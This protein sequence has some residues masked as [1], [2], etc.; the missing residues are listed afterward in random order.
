MSVSRNSSNILHYKEFCTVLLKKNIWN[1]ENVESLNPISSYLLPQYQVLAPP[2]Q[3]SSFYTVF[4]HT[5]YLL[6]CNVKNEKEI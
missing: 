5:I 2:N 4:R 1:I 6:I 3:V